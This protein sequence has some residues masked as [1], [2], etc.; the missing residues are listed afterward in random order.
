MCWTVTV[1]RTDDFRT[2]HLCLEGGLSLLLGQTSIWVPGNWV[3]MTVGC[4]KACGR[5]SSDGRHSGPL[6]LVFFGKIKGLER[7]TP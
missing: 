2:A 1:C 6:G 3:C 4:Q 5:V 7:V